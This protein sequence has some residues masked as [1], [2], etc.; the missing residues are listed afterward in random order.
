MEKADEE[1]LKIARELDKKIVSA[2]MQIKM[3]NT[4]KGPAV[5]SLRAQADKNRYKEE[6]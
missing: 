6:R 1:G 4:S 5:Y 3:L 2:W